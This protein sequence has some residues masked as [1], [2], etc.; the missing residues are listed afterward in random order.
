MRC[1]SHLSWPACSRQVWELLALCSTWE[2]PTNTSFRNQ[3]ESV[4]SALVSAS[5][6]I[7]THTVRWRWSRTG[8]VDWVWQKCILISPVIFQSQENLRN[9]GERDRKVKEQVIPK[10]LECAI[11]TMCKCCLLLCN[12]P[13]CC[14]D[15]THVQQFCTL[16]NEGN[17]PRIW[18]LNMETFM[19]WFFKLASLFISQLKD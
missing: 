12:G 10:W 6:L 15:I 11:V 1:I 2:P 7:R 13:S 19:F 4:F 16:Y 9:R 14:H 5:I 8:E 18:I 17:V 3:E